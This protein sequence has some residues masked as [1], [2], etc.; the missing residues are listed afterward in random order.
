MRKITR[1]I[2][3]VVLLFFLTGSCTELLSTYVRF[4]NDSTTKTVSAIWDGINSATLSPGEINEYRQVNPGI[5]T[6]QWKNANT[7]KDLTSLGYPNLV[8][9]KSYT[10]P[11]ND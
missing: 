5:H 2:I 11:Y 4:R 9:G 1:I 8:R 3:F 10:Y 7:G 6:I